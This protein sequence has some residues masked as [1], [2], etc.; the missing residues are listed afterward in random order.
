MR[1]KINAALRSDLIKVSSKTGIATAIRIGASFIISK[2]LAIFVGPSGLAI[3]GQLNNASNII[4]SLS[5]GG[6]TVGVT[7]YISEFSDRRESQI[8]IINTSLKLTFLCSAICSFGVLVSYKFLGYRLFHSN[9][10][11]QILLILGTTLILFSFNSLITAIINGLR[12]FKLYIIINI[13]TSLISL[14]TTLVFVYSLGVYGSLLSLVLS[15]TLIFFISWF[16]VRKEGWLNYQFF[17]IPFDRK[18]LKLLSTFSLMAINNAIVGAIAQIA[19][20]SLITGKMNIDVAGIWDGMNKL[21]AGYMLLITTSIQVYYL[22]T[23]SFIKDKKLLWKEII[24]TEKIILPLSLLL[25]TI[26][27]IFRGFIINMLFSKEFYLMKSIFAYQLLGDIIKIASWILSYTMYAKAMA[28]QLIITDNLF[29][30]I[31][32][33]TSYLFMKNL[34]YGLNAV[35]YSYIINNLIYLIFMYFFMKKYTSKI[36]E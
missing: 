19:I 21:S 4:Q 2:I 12:N 31:Y 9:K 16:L 13:F 24:K 22:P 28:K 1:V 30:L 8:K 5:T 36:Y 25:F 20:R 34:D 11:D 23:L 17:K 29:T 15:P 14:I 10:Y 3:L 26:I 6:I 32:V 27:F 7:K 35:Y 33:F 18:S